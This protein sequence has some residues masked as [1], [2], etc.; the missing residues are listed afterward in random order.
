MK[1]NSLKSQFHQQ[2]VNLG[3]FSGLTL[4]KLPRLGLRPH[5]SSV[6]LAGTT[7]T[8]RAIST[9]FIILQVLRG[10]DRL[11]VDDDDDVGG[12]GGGGRQQR[13]EAEHG[14]VIVV[15]VAGNESF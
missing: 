2:N 8:G 5:L 1:L 12:G 11:A 3:K 10:R 4:P 9:D 13:N 14:H 6:A 7:S 15:V